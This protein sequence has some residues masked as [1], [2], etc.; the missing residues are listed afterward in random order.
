MGWAEYLSFLGSPTIVLSLIL[1]DCFQQGKFGYSRC[2]TWHWLGT[3]EMPIRSVS[4]CAR[5]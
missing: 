4:T 3:A 2:E 1:V 5:K